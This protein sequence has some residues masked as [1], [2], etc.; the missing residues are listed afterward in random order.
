MIQGVLIGSTPLVKIAISWK[1]S[2]IFPHVIV[3]T[4]FTGDIQITTEIARA[5][6]L[7][8][9][10]FTQVRIA[11]GDLITVKTGVALVILEGV[12]KYVEVLFSL[13]EPLLGVGLLKKFG[14]RAI[15]DGKNNTVF[16]EK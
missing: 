6:K 5:L 1:N 4:G 14:Y 15:V 7:T 8:P 13:G 3:D 12:K 9:T 10:S 11:N 16:L 2:V